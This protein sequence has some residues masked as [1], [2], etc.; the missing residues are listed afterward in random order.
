M[1]IWT[2]VKQHPK[3]GLIALALIAFVASGCPMACSALAGHQSE[4]GFSIPLDA[5]G[6]F[7]TLVVA[8]Y[9]TPAF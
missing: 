5:I 1:N 9:T 2:K 6:V 3:L 4:A 7:L 8:G